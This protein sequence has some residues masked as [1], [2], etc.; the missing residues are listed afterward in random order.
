[1]LRCPRT[2]R[3]FS[4]GIGADEASFGRLPDTVSTAPCPRC[5][6]EH[7]WRPH[8]AWLVEAIPLGERPGAHRRDQVGPPDGNAAA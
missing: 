1:M 6:Q 2:G 8:D 3:D 4:T 5:G 7:P